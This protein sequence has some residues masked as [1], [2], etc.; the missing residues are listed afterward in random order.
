MTKQERIKKLYK[1]QQKGCLSQSLECGFNCPLYQQVE[2]EK[3]TIQM[4]NCMISS[5]DNAEKELSKYTTEEL[6]E[7]LI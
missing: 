2:L 6:F 5:R 1:L 7:V 3:Q 4:F